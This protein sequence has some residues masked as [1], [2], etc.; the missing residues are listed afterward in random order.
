MKKSEIAKRMARQAGVSQAEAADRLDHAV[1]QILSS[2]RQG[3]QA[4]LP[5]L[6]TFTACP[7]G[8]VAFARQGEKRR[9]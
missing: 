8:K 4:S 6:G 2:L 7:G 3:K 1:H 9:G 5:G